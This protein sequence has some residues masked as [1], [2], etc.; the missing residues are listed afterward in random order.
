LEQKNG[1]EELRSNRAEVRF[2]IANN[3]KPNQN[4]GEKSKN[5]KS[6]FLPGASVC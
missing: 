3:L 5:N 4:Y 6:T 2:Q 1:P